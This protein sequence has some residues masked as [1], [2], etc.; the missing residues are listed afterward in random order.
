MKKNICLLVLLLCTSLLFSEPRIKKGSSFTVMGVFEL[1]TECGVDKEILYRTLNHE[2]GMKVI[3]LE[4]GK[5][6][7]INNV[8]G[9]WLHVLTTAPMWVDTLEWVEKYKTYWIFL[10]ESTPITEY[11]EY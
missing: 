10:P 1:R 3:T 8:E 6:E 2:G 11:E 9:L 5:S 7:T 4:V